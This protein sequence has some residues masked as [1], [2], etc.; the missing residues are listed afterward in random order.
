VKASRSSVP[1]SEFDHNDYLYTAAF[2]DIFLLGKFYKD[3][4]GSLTW[5]QRCHLLLQFTGAP[6]KSRHLIFYMFNQQMR[7]GNIQGVSNTVKATPK[8]FEKFAELANSNKFKEKVKN[9]AKDPK[10]G[11]AKYIINTMLPV[12]NI[13]SKRNVFSSSSNAL[14][15]MIAMSH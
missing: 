10:S 1:I 2:P 4:K 6:A 14:T 15:K 8:A 5:A 7:H 13:S 12:L 11:D 3:K 9:A